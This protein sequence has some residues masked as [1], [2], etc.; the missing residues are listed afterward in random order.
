MNWIRKSVLAVL[1]SCF[2]ILAIQN[3]RLEGKRHRAAL[4]EQE[5]AVEKKRFD[6]LRHRFQRVRK[7]FEPAVPVQPDQPRPLLNRAA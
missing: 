7:H 3:L 5:M 1:A 4:L 2:V 6:E